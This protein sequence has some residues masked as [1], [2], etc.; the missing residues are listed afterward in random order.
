[1]LTSIIVL[2]YNQLEYTMQCIDSIKTFTN[3]NEYEL[4]IVDNAST[5]GTVEWL[6]KQKDIKVIY[7]RDN[8]GFPKG[9]NQGIKIA[10]GE[11]ILLLNNDTVV[12]YNWLENLVKCLY[13]DESIGAVGPVTNS[14]AYYSTIPVSYNSIEE[15]H[16]F[17]REYNLLDKEKWE[18]RLKLVGFC[19]LIKRE[20]INKIGLLDEI[21]TPGNYEDDDYSLRMRKAGYKLIFCK[22]TFIHHFGSV[23]W[24][25]E[26]KDFSNLLSKNHQLFIDKW[27]IDPS[28]FVIHKELI[29]LIDIID[30]SNLKI[31]QIGCKTGATLLALKSKFKNAEVFGVEKDPILNIEASEYAT[32]VNIDLDNTLLPFEQGFFDIILFTDFSFV[33]SPG[34]LIKGIIPYLKSNGLLLSQFPNLSNVQNIRK[35]LFGDNPVTN[36]KRLFTLNEIDALINEVEIS[37]EVIGLKHPLSDNDDTYIQHL[38]ELSHPDLKTQF[39]TSAFLIKAKNT[40]QHENKK[41]E[42]N[43]E[44]IVEGKIIN[45]FDLKLLIRRIE[46]GIEKQVSEMEFVKRLSSREVS[47][48]EILEVVLRDIINKEDV[49]NLLAILCYE[50]RLYEQILPFLKCAYELNVHNNNTLFNLGYFLAQFGEHRV[51]LNYLKQI[52]YKDAEVLELIAQLEGVNS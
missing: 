19:L 47:E 34:E 18:E 49:L 35:I 43:S 44:D 16:E 28:D 42:E 11:N 7:N 36:N 5:D 12:T 38:L 23:S 14:L 3:K 29:D 50:N 51:A 33:T 6:K 26:Y 52:S 45:N 48:T 31:L 13:S 37:A 41:L 32:I 20:V 22:D 9:C 27:N 15:M 30:E 17:A 24:K 4:I 10:Q 21:F 25:K 2:T 39:E 40:V 46:F 1:M 8:L